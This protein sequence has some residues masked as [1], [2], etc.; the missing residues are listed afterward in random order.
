MS[1]RDEVFERISDVNDS[2]SSLWNIIDK[3]Q[4]QISD[5]NDRIFAL[6]CKYMELMR[7]LGEANKMFG[8]TLNENKGKYDPKE[9]AKINEA[10]GEI[11]KMAQDAETGKGLFPDRD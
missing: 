8:H 5:S 7:C 9:Y 11:M 2:I 10:L 4:D 6:Q 3:I 1:F